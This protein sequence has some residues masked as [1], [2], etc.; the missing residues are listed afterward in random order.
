M[1]NSAV[2]GLTRERMI[3]MFISISMEQT[4]TNTTDR[5]K[6]GEPDVSWTP[7]R[8]RM[9]VKKKKEKEWITSTLTVSVTV[10]G[11]V[12][13]F[14][15]LFF[16]SLYSVTTEVKLNVDPAWRNPNHPL[17]V[18]IMKIHHSP[19]VNSAH[20]HSQNG[21]SF[22]AGSSAGPTPERAAVADWSR[23]PVSVQ[24]LG[25]WTVVLGRWG[26]SAGGS[27]ANQRWWSQ[28]ELNIDFFIF[29][30]LFVRSIIMKDLI[31]NSSAGVLWFWMMNYTE[32]ILCITLY[33]INSAPKLICHDNPFNLLQRG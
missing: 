15:V 16:P 1:I 21:K 18:V 9:T 33:G 5:A 6:A 31:A 26:Q 20:L 3:F 27:N 25:D 11:A 28:M 7:C 23:N 4:N 17:L 13:L 8:L 19:S 14:D 10:T 30:L 12:G 22:T 29:I 32:Y 2:S 24:W